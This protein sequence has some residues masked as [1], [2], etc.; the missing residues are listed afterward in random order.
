MS[1]FHY[2]KIKHLRK[3]DPP[4]YSNYKAYKPFLREEF[5]AT[6]VYCRM[7][8]RLSSHDNFGVDHYRPK[9]HFPSLATSYPNLYY[10]CNTCNRLK[11]KFWPNNEQ[12]VLKLFVP[13]PCDHKMHEHLRVTST[14]QIEARSSAGRW[15]SDI[16]RLNDS[17]RVELR[18]AMLRAVKLAISVR[19]SLLKTIAE[20]VRQAQVATGVAQSELVAMR[21]KQE[22]ELEEA[23]AL[24]ARLEGPQ[25]G[26]F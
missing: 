21:Q 5:D 10:A 19:A 13:N 8:E 20:L 7:P 4:T 1:L 22:I 23:E 16:L 24:L 26:N 6:C 3:L 11:G 17:E 18:L 15:T 14:G 9:H 2:P 25:S 12:V